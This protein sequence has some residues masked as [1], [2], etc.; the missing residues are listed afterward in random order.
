MSVGKVCADVWLKERNL[1]KMM[2]VSSKIPNSIQVTVSE[3]E[4]DG[5]HC[6]AYQ[7]GLFTCSFHGL[8]LPGFLPFKL[9]KACSDSYLYSEGNFWCK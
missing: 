2:S 4:F 7:S 6:E 3:I 1:I 8:F 9:Q 5:W